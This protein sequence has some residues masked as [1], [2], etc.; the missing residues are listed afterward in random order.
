MKAATNEVRFIASGLKGSSLIRPAQLDR[1]TSILSS[2]VFLC[3]L[4]CSFSC[5]SVAQNSATA[6]TQRAQP[7]TLA[8]KLASL[9]QGISFRNEPL[10]AKGKDP[11][12]GARYVYQRSGKENARQSPVDIDI[13][14]LG[15]NGEHLHKHFAKDIQALYQTIYG[16]SPKSWAGA[17]K[18]DKDS[19]AILNTKSNFF[20]ES[21]AQ[22]VAESVFGEPVSPDVYV[23][24]P[25]ASKSQQAALKA[26]FASVHTVIVRTHIDGSRDPLN[27]ITRRI[28]YIAERGRI[29]HPEILLEVAFPVELNIASEH[30]EWLDMRPK[31]AGAYD[32]LKS[33][34]L[35]AE[36]PSSAIE[37]TENT[38]YPDFNLLYIPIRHLVLQGQV[39]DPKKSRA[40]MSYESRDALRRAVDDLVGKLRDKAAAIK[41]AEDLKAFLTSKYYYMFDQGAGVASYRDY[42][43]G[44]YGVAGSISPHIDRVELILE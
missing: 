31:I 10:P 43:L 30:Q 37:R 32:N 21:L 25:K 44:K 3:L 40:A 24:G 38:H 20:W 2:A 36:V 26:R 4:A 12:A 41:V 14:L 11:V 1:M 6:D 34:R 35:L 39:D 27:P 19:A 23:Y 33:I 8:Q 7:E 29:K 5:T 22:H 9:P 18:G 28:A 42:I 15:R 13:I 16:W 17:L